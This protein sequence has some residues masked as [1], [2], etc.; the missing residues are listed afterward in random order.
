MVSTFRQNVA[1]G[2]SNRTK[3]Q[4]R[5]YFCTDCKGWHMTSWETPDSPERMCKHGFVLAQ[6]IQPACVEYNRSIS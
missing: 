2:L 6:C 5:C 1:E 4:C 3:V